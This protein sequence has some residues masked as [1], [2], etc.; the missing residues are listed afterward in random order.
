MYLPL[1]ASPLCPSLAVTVSFTLLLVIL[2]VA[3]LTSGDTV[4]FILVLAYSPEFIPS[5]NL[6]YTFVLWARLLIV[7]PLAISVHSPVV[8]F[9]W[10]YSEIARFVLTFILAFPPDQVGFVNVIAPLVVPAGTRFV[11]PVTS[12]SFV[13]PALSVTTTF[14]V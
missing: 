11:F 14:N 12:A 10:Y 1:S 9:I 3:I 7:P 5:V 13:N 4:S 8:P 2:L 6:A